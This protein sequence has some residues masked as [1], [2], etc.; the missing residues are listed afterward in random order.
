MVQVERPRARRYPF[1]ASVELTDLRSET[2]TREQTS[3]LSLFGCHIEKAQP[4]PT[5][6]RVRVR[7][8]YK[9]E[10]FEAVGRVTNN[11]SKSGI[12]IVFTKIEENH[13]AVL[14]KWLGEVRDRAEKLS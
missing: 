6:A 14:E 9:R 3:D 1:N 5:G 8:A 12:G 11:Q 7:I 10:I 13:Q 4:L 2:S